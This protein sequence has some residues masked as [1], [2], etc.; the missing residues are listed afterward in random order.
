MIF[1]VLSHW[2]AS[3]R[4]NWKGL[5][6]WLSFVVYN[7]EFVTFPLVSWVRYGNW[8]YRSSWS[9]HPYFASSR[10]TGVAVLCPLAR[11]F[12][13]FLVL[14]KYGKTD[15]RPDMTEKNVKRNVKRLHRQIKYTLHYFSVHRFCIS[16]LKTLYS[17]THLHLSRTC[18]HVSIRCCI[19]FPFAYT[20]SYAATPDNSITR[21]YE[22][23]I[24]T[25][26]KKLRGNKQQLEKLQ[27]KH[28]TIVFFA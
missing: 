11:H 13:R 23:K 28:E 19:T 4:R 22:M 7:C 15:N 3:N 18:V 10:L 8:L 6:S 1:H 27:E 9:L 26:G 14:V 25:V 5:T 2:L 24:L 16:M 20:Y 17:N 21:L 12:I